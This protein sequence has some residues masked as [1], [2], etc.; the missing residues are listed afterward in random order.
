[1]IITRLTFFSFATTAMSVLVT[2]ALVSLLT[3]LFCSLV[4]VLA[5]LLITLLY[6]LQILSGS[7]FELQNFM[8]LAHFLIMSQSFIVIHDHD[9]CMSH[10]Y[11]VV[12]LDLLSSSHVCSLLAG[13]TGREGNKFK[14]TNTKVEVKNDGR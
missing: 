5:P 7:Y 3:T 8:D 14:S 4:P 11:L 1:M 10:L 12:Y 6:F 13:I 9:Y 2:P